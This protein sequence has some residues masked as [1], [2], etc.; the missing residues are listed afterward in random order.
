MHV[1]LFVKVV[2]TSLLAGIWYQIYEFSPEAPLL[3]KGQS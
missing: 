3:F 2:L 1:S